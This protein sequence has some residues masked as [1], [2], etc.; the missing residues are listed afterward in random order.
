MGNAEHNLGA[1][2]SY[3][4]VRCKEPYQHCGKRNELNYNAVLMR[5]LL[6]HDCD[7]CQYSRIL[8]AF[9]FLHRNATPITGSE[10]KC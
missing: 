4:H 3:I 10:R 1:M 5:Q 8:Q 7:A 9:S 2:E 6:R